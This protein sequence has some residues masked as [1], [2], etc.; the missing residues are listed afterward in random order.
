MFYYGNQRNAS[1]ILSEQN[2]KIESK[3]AT[4]STLKKMVKLVDEAEKY[5]IV[6]DF[7]NFGYLLNETW[8][9]KKTLA[10]NISD[11]K[12]DDIYKIGIDSGAYG[13]KLLGAGGGGFFLFYIRNE[14][15]LKLI[16]N[17]SFL[18]EFDFK[19]ED[20]GST[21]IINNK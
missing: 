18:K 3:I 15:R 2:K 12:I 21:I 10:S 16:N 4:Q 11:K 19:F 5:L 9:L 20:T 1:D 8:N 6:K 13:G 7:D 17:L 14:D